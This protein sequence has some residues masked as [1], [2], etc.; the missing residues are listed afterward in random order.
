VVAFEVVHSDSLFLQLLLGLVLRVGRLDLVQ[1]AVTSS[2]VASRPSFSATHQDFVVD[3]LARMLKR[4]L[5][6]CLPRAAGGASRLVLVV[7]LDV[8]SKNFLP[9]TVATTSA[10]PCFDGQA[11]QK[12]QGARRDQCRRIHRIEFQT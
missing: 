11:I 5:V 10:P 4:K 1:F 2:S 8:R 6:A 3:Q 9:S 7:L 12:R